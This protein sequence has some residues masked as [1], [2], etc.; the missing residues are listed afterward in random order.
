MKA[1]RISIMFMAAAGALLILATVRPAAAQ[2]PEYE[3]AYVNGKTVTIN[4]IEL[5]QRA[6]LQAQADFSLVVYPWAVVGWQSLGVPPPQCS[7]CDHSG[8]G[9][10]FDDY[11]DHVL[12]SMPAD[13]GH[14]EF[15]TLWHMF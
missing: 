2:T 14:G 7:P 13:P 5:Q 12:D 3:P 8:D 10:T 15:R 11:H 9:P 1:N 6:P 4:A